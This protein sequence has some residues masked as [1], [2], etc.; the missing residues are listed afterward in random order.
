MLVLL[1]LGC[2]EFERFNVRMQVGF[3]RL[4][5]M[6]LLRIVLALDM[7]IIIPVGYAQTAAVWSVL[8]IGSTSHTEFL[9]DY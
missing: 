1:V 4:V 9:E 3:W 7:H 5:F 6:E 2:F 8:L